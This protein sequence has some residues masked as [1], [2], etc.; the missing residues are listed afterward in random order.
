MITLRR[1]HEGERLMASPWVEKLRAFHAAAYH[2][3]LS[4]PELE[5][6][7]QQ[8]DSMIVNQEA[9]LPPP[10]KQPAARLPA[11][12]VPIALSATDH[13]RLM[14]CPY[15]YFCASGLGLALE[16]EVREEMEKADF[17][18]HVHRILQAFHAG[19]LGLPG[20]WKKPL[21]DDTLSEAADLLREISGSV[22]AND[23]Q[24]NF[25]TRGW[26]YRWEKCIPAYLAWE[27][28]HGSRW[29]IQAAE[30]KKESEYH[31]SGIHVVLKGRIDRLDRGADDG[32]RLIDY[33]T[34]MVP[35]RQ[36]VHRGEKI[37]LP[38]YALLLG[39]EKVAQALFLSIGDGE[40]TERNKLEGEILRTL[41]TAA[42]ERIL[43]LKQQLDEEYPLP[44]W[45]DLETCNL[46]DMEGLC[47]RGLW[48]EQIQ[49][50]AQA[51]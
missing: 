43:M 24:R 23:L 30:W 50:T 45:G 44:A 38:F 26:L 32:Y 12:L 15:Q 49:V 37:Q 35:T 17:G 36:Q 34:G 29:Q 47:R 7:V 13:Q 22:F 31:R 1:E 21:T 41:T 18:M 5:W 8:P 33:K 19:V 48:N 46:C 25:L 42:K 14:D 28:E 40:V 3:N 9:P 6:L 27:Q 20:P 51:K 10:V 2:E 11:G 39:D 16:E 4:S